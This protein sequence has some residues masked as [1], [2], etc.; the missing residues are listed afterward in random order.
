MKRHSVLV[1]LLAI[2]ACGEPEGADKRTGPLDGIDPTP[3]PLPET[4]T[5]RTSYEQPC[6]L[7]VPADVTALIEKTKKENETARDL[8]VRLERTRLGVE[9]L[10]PTTI[11]GMGYQGD[12]EILPDT[13]PFPES[14]V[15]AGDLTYDVRT[16]GYQLNHGKM[17]METIYETKPGSGQYFIVDMIDGDG[18]GGNGREVIAYTVEYGL[19]DPAAD[20]N[21]HSWHSWHVSPDNVIVRATQ[22]VEDDVLQEI[23]VCGCGGLDEVEVDADGKVID[24]EGDS[25][26]AGDVA[27]ASYA[28]AIFMLPGKGQPKISTETF[29]AAFKRSYVKQKFVPAK[30]RRCINR[31][32]ETC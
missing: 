11:I 1:F 19:Y 29:E 23:N 26:Q 6:E 18:V 16:N 28:V 4:E 22:K 12:N 7:E 13:D 17:D 5:T 8:A 31:S 9:P 30:G 24:D 2:A 15:V 32:M 21:G 27:P 3:P 14:V 25:S 20:L 10:R